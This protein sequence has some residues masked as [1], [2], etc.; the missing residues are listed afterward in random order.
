MRKKR[1]SDNF[2]HQTLD[3]AF[4]DILQSASDILS[5]CAVEPPQIQVEE[6]SWRNAQLVGSFIVIAENVMG[7]TIIDPNGEPILQYGNRC[8]IFRLQNVEVVNKGINWSFG[9]CILET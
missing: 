9:D 7:S 1:H 6:F 8:S 4:L 3:G 5:R 2:L